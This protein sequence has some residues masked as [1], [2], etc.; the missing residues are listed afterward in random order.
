MPTTFARCLALLAGALILL[1]LP[2]VAAAAPTAYVASYETPGKVYPLDT[3]TNTVGTAIPV[4]SSPWP[5]AITPDGATAYVANSASN[6]V[7]P[8]DTSTNTPGTPIAVGSGPQ[9]IAI[10]P[11]GT[12]AY[13]G[14]RG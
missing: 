3:A 7:T 11:D 4:G 10:T 6:N 8:I 14:Q 12:T 13:V 2:A 5:I 9:S 1:A